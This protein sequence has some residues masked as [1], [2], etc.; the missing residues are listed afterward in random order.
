M[1][2]KIPSLITFELTFLDECVYNIDTLD[3][4]SET[5]FN[6]T[7]L[8]MFANHVKDVCSKAKPGDR[9]EYRDVGL[10]IECK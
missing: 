3:N 8:L 6:V 10:I 2:K 1:R 4:V 9:F 5:I 7:G